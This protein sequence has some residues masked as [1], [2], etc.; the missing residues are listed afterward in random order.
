MARREVNSPG[1][2]GAFPFDTSRILD[3]EV[4]GS[5]VTD[6]CRVAW[7]WDWRCAVFGLR[8]ARRVQVVLSA[9]VGGSVRLDAPNFCSLSEP[10]G[11]V[12]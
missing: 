1:S 4:A 9:G 11:E 7:F 2:A 12:W 5:G 10:D 3:A 6:F 8:F